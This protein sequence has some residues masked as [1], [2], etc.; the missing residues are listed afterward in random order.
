[1]GVASPA[2]DL[3]P[4]AAGAGYLMSCREYSAAA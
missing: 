4:S 2:D 3:L 1:M